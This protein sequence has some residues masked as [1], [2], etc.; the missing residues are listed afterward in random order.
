M[1][2]HIKR[3]LARIDAKHDVINRKSRNEAKE[4]GIVTFFIGVAIFWGLVISVTYTALEQ[5]L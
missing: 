1:S 5:L 2:R 3:N 4:I